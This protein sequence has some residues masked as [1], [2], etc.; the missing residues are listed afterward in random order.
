MCQI[1][2]L[3]EGFYSNM[4]IVHKERRGSETCHQLGSLK[5][6]CEIRAFQDGGATYSENS[7]KEKQLD[8]QSGSE[9]FLLYG[10]NSPSISSFPTLQVGREDILIQMF[11]LWSM[12]SPKGIHKDSQAISGDAQISGYVTSNL[13]GRYAT[14]GKLQLEAIGS[15]PDVIVPP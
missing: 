10:P 8:C 7:L 9:G 3:T 1:S 11:P 15:H 12:H 2:A 5:Q 14:D 13:H 4:F 6:I